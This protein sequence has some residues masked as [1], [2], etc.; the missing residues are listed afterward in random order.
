MSVWVLRRA[1]HGAR[2]A[3]K[4]EEQLEGL[5]QHIFLIVSPSLLI[6]FIDSY[7]GKKEHK[8]STERASGPSCII[9]HKAMHE[10]HGLSGGVTCPL[11]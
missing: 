1:R 2:A 10:G 4:T 11:R 6:F 9:H 8:G 3:E 7:H 5:T